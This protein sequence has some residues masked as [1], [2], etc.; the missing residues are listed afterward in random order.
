MGEQELK[1]KSKAKEITQ[2]EKYIEK[3]EF[4]KAL[5]LLNIIDKKNDIHHHDKLTSYHLRGQLLIWQGNYKEAI[6]ILEEMYRISQLY[7]YKL[8]SVDALVLLSHIYTYKFQDVKALDIIEQAKKLL[9]EL[10]Q[11][12][13][14]ALFARE[15]HLLFCQGLIFFHEGNLIQALEY[16]ERSVALREE[17]GN[18]QDLA[19]SL[20]NIG[21]ILVKDGQIDRALKLL[22][23]SLTLATESNNLFC[24][25]LC[26]NTLGATCLFKGKIGLSITNFEKS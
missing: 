8:H 1:K 7:D 2:A 5:K 17:I 21:R 6:K 22:E 9:Q 20:Y 13:S 11:E 19:E 4:D 25:G 14:E 24:K 15:S 18:K 26:Y 16:L 10:S 12:S 3:G 23:R